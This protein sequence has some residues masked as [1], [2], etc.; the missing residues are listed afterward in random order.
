[1]LPPGGEGEVEVTLTPKGNHEEII[2]RIIV[3]SNDP[4]QPRF[5]LTMQ[6]KLLVDVKAEPS[7]LNLTEIKPGEPATV[8]FTVK[9]TDPETTKIESVVV[10]DQE[11]FEVHPLEPE[12]DGQPR[13]ELRF[14]G[15]KTVGN[16]GTRVEVN[17][18]APHTPRLNIP[19]RAAVVSN[20]RYGKRLHFTRR[21]QGFYSPNIRV[22]TR[23]GKPPKIEK[24]EDPDGLLALEI[25]D[26]VGAT[27]T[28]QAQVDKAKY[29]A[30]SESQRRKSHKLTVHTNDPHEPRV[31]ITYT[32]AGT[33]PALRAEGASPS[34]QDV[35]ATLRE[36]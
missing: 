8:S 36:Q 4:K 31:E 7:N 22:S 16:F 32:I 33:Q 28:I 21:D 24:V 12:A 20:L 13:Y 6:G 9:I 10:E 1:V 25:L 27:V 19:V 17:T 14:R 30:L 26:P 34:D 18:T 3:I 5:T 35:P 2:K 29:E 11:N 15:S 23:D